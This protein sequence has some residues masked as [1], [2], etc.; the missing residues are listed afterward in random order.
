[1]IETWLCLNELPSSLISTQCLLVLGVKYIYHMKN[2]IKKFD[3]L[4]LWKILRYFA[5]TSLF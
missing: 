4:I 3:H 1:M 2:E 5:T